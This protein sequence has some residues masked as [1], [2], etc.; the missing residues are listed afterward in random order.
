MCH[1]ILFAPVMAL[2]LFWLLP[3]FVALPIFGIVVVVTALV[4]WPAVVALRRPPVTGCEGMVGAR[5]EA[6]TELNPHG[7]I[8]CE[9]EVWSATADEPIA[10]GERVRVVATERLRARV[11][12][13]I[14]VRG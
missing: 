6:L 10:G 14:P 12:R 8:R 11:T 7:L 13:Y 9:G 5:G 1:L 2:S 4:G 3:T